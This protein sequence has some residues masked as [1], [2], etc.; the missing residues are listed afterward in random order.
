[1]GKKHQAESITISPPDLIQAGSLSPILVD[2]R[3]QN[4]GNNVLKL[5]KWGKSII[6]SP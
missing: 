2:Y 6:L 1:M 5:A 3:R 4:N